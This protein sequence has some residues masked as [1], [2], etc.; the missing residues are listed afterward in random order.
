MEQSD[1]SKV[2]L[3][4]IDAA[5]FSKDDL[6]TLQKLVDME[7]SNLYDVLEYVFNGHY[8]A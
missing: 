2:F 5:G 1:N 4:N 6:L 7:K 8:I 3:E